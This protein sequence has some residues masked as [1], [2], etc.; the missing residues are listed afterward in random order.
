MYSGS[1]VYRKLDAL[2]YTSH[3]N[4][5]LE[6]LLDANERPGDVLIAELVRLQRLV[7]DITSI[8]PYD[9]PDRPQA[10][11]TPFLMHL[12]ALSKSLDDYQESLPDPLGKHGKL[13]HRAMN[14]L[15]T[16]LLMLQTCC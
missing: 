11:G 4:D 1:T 15:M 6:A 12:R 16:H 10:F 13:L 14:F 2:P 8:V 9:E 5:E 3:L 7:H